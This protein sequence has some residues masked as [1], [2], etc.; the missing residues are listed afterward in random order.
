MEWSGSLR[1]F[2]V[3]KYPIQIWRW[4]VT[5]TQGGLVKQTQIWSRLL[6]G[7][8]G[9]LVKQRAVCLGSDKTPVRRTLH[10]GGCFHPACTPAKTWSFQQV[11]L[12]SS[13]GGAERRKR[14]DPQKLYS[15]IWGNFFFSH[16]KDL[17]SFLKL[18][19]NWYI[20]HCAT[21]RCTICIFL[22]CKQPVTCTIL[23]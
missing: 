14:L 11:H 20:Q 21:S 12:S 1:A 19:Y 13:A 18:R 15:R 10:S 5:G 2:W 6:T 22:V 3:W 8:Q 4:L 23:K 7:T 16:F 17:I 9:G